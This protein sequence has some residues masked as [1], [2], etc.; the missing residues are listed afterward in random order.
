MKRLADLIQ[1]KRLI[2]FGTGSTSQKYTEILLNKGVTINN[3]CDNNNN[4]WFTQF[5]EVEVIS[6]K[7]LNFNR[8][9]VLIVSEYETEISEQLIK[10]GFTEHMNYLY[11]SN[12]LILKDTIYYC[13][14]GR[15]F[16]LL[17]NVKS[18]EE[19]QIDIDF[20]ST[21]ILKNE[22][23]RK[24]ITPINLTKDQYPSFMIP[25]QKYPL[26]SVNIY[27]FMDGITYGENGT[28]ISKEGFLIKEFS[29]F[30]S[31]AI[32]TW[33][34]QRIKQLDF[35][36]YSKKPFIVKLT[37]DVA[38]TTT[39]WSGINFYHW[40]F[41]ELP[42]FY[43]L[44]KYEG[45]IDY[46]ISNFSNKPYQLETLKLL[47][48]EVK[49]LISPSGKY[50]IQASNL[51]ISYSPAFDS[52][53]VSSWICN[54]IKKIFLPFLDDNSS[55]GYA[56]RVYIARG[57]A[58]NRKVVNEVEII[59]ILRNNGFQICYLDNYTLIEQANIFYHAKVIIAPHGAA[60]TNLVHCKEK[61][62][63]LEI[64]NPTY[65]PTMFWEIS[66]KM[67]L[68]YYCSVGERTD[69][70]FTENITDYPNTKNINIKAEDIIKFINII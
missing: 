70:E 36:N 3:F 51:I 55:D 11:Y 15:D 39:Q 67:G 21:P 38:V 40:M 20:Q 16:P 33:D 35:T 8:D 49:K 24:F 23:V 60:L 52:G 12:L 6:P 22:Y 57:N 53:Y 26:E 44:S 2:L 64:F 18:I 61:T 9:I 27:Q 45:N 47:N 32:N 41:E 37:N 66:S 68:D 42:R 4:I 46:Y 1:N 65:A 56:E 59:N 31:L 13:L 5:H 10:M 48:I 50:G 34:A 19:C 25:Q 14:Q 29:T 7:K 54:F 28:V 62:K 58:L 17:K 30:N 69:F 43:L 63:V